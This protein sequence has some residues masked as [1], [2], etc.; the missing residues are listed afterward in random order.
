MFEFIQIKKNTI[1]T[2]GKSVI[3]IDVVLNIHMQW[4]LIYKKSITKR[5]PINITKEIQYADAILAIEN[6]VKNN[7]AVGLIFGSHYIAEEVFHAFEIP[8]DN[9]YI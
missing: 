2:I 3:I 7:S 5:L 4:H 9:Y 6:L 8:F 1:V